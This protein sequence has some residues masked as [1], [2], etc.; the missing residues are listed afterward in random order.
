MKEFISGK[1][2]RDKLRK[3]LNTA[4]F[5]QVGI[6][7]IAGRFFVS[8]S[9]GRLICGKLRILMLVNLISEDSLTFR[10]RLKRRSVTA[11]AAAPRGIALAVVF[12]CFLSLSIFAQQDDSQKPPVIVQ[13]GAPGQATRILPST[14]RAKL[15]PVSAK[16]VEFMQQMIM[17]HAQAVEM[18][19]LIESRTENRNIRLLG[20]RISRSQSDEIQVMKGWLK[21]RG[22]PV[23]PA[24]PEMTEMP[25]MNHS[26][27]QMLM[28][29]MLTAEQMDAL[30]K[31]KSAEK[32]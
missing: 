27:H 17:H 25:G 1:A 16:D 18:T 5:I 15:L 12:M 2:W 28:P 20:A 26:S 11:V 3:K 30:K 31:A 9:A 4:F 24:M 29:G 8:G 22:E 23:A 19:A 32:K 7:F 13:P 21:L 6:T 10:S 14:T